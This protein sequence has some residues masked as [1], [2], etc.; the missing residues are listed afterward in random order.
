MTM[1]VALITILLFSISLFGM[2]PLHAC[3]MF[4]F[5]TALGDTQAFFT[6][7]ATPD[8]VLAGPGA[9]SVSSGHGH[10]GRTDRRAVYGQVV[11]LAQLGGPAAALIPP[12]AAEVVVVPWDY[13]GACEPLAWGLSARFVAPEGSAFYI[14]SLRAPEHWV[15][16]TPTFD[17]R[18]PR[19]LPYTGTERIREM[20][21]DETVAS[22]LSPEQIFEFYRALPTNEEVAARKTEALGSL[23]QWVRAHPE[24]AQRPQVQRLLGQVVGSVDRAELE[25]VQHPVLGTWRFHL[26]VPG[27][28]VHSFYA[29]TH[30]YPTLRWAPSREPASALSADLRLPAAE[31]YMFLV[32]VAGT[33][34]GL[35]EGGRTGVHAQAYVYALALPDTV[36]PQS[37]TWRG[38]LES[39]LLRRAMPDDPVVQEADSVARERFGSRYQQGLPGETPASFSRGA[40]G[41]IRVQQSFPLSDGRVLVLEGEQISSRVIQTSR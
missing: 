6:G 1:R 14:A 39:S 37:A 19:N 9:V 28:S 8:T 25:E 10:F 26:R 31:G 17:L 16:G 7:H 20:G 18:N 36:R 21:R 23:R 33:L 35:P 30:P 5:H 2:P 12:G 40:D 38:W 11:R 3:S 24:L 41:V 22:L 15:D 29:R 32:A 4:T 27:E 34:D 13:N